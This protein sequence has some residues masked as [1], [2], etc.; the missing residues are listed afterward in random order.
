MYRLTAATGDK[1]YTDAGT[2]TGDARRNLRTGANN[3][4]HPAWAQAKRGNWSI[5]GGGG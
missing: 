4:H 3:F 5:V 1:S 2:P